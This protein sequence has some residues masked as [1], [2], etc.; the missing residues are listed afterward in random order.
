MMAEAD[1][2]AQGED[3]RIVASREIFE[4]LLNRCARARLSV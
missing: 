3:P 4:E 2:A 1:P